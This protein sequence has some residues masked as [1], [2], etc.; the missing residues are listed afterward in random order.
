MSRRTHKKYSS[1]LRLKA[2]ED[3]LSD[4]GAMKQIREKYGILAN[5]QLINWIKWYNG[6]RDF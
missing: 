6:H 4:K 3:Y 5:K 1:E 2:V